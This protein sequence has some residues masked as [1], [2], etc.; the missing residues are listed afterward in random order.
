MTFDTRWDNGA[1]IVG[2]RRFSSRRRVRLGGGEVKG[3]VANMAWVQ[4]P[5]PSCDTSLIWVTVSVDPA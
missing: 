2:I 5:D 3:A 1:L 4:A